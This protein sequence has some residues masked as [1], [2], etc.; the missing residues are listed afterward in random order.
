MTRKWI[1]LLICAFMVTGLS[2]CGGQ[3]EVKDSRSDM[4]TEKNEIDEKEEGEPVELVASWWGSQIR[5][6]RFISCFDLYTEQ[7][8]D[9]SIETQTSSFD[10]YFVTL[11]AAAAGGTLP[12][13]MMSQ[14]DYM[15][16]YVN[17]GQL[18]D[19]TPYIE[20][21]ALDVS[22]VS[23]AVLDTGRMGDGV[24]GITAGTAA[25][26]MV[27][28][29]TLLDDLGIEIKDFMTID[30]FTSICKEVFEKTGVKTF[31]GGP[32]D[33]MEMMLRSEGK[34]LFEDG[35]LGVDSWEELLPYWELLEQGNEE[36]WL[37]DY[38]V[39]IGR[40]ALEEDPLINFT[41]PETQ[42]WCA[43]YNSNQMAAL[44]AA[45][46]EAVKLGITTRPSDDANKS[47]YVRQSMC[48]TVSAA[49]QHVDETIAL[50]NW[51]LNNEEPNDIIK[52]E[53]GVPAS[54]VVAEHVAEG[55]DETSSMIFNYITN[56]V[57]PNSSPA[58]PVPPSGVSQIRDGLMEDI[59]EKVYYGEYTPEQAAKELY[60]Q[61][62]KILQE[63]KE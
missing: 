16:P 58:N 14:S 49:S 25:L 53:P 44:Q 26:S 46:P 22:N 42:S 47:N 20:S 56:V 29:K 2:A 9:V 21:G 63:A 36:G 30:D 8:K 45:A 37:L 34:V 48:W 39:R 38:S 7:N 27:Y 41:S 23:K 52:G 33:G 3:G 31:L 59:N 55:L 40:T 19:L 1:S 10:D 60:E 51:W 18:L 15:A 12:D 61:G 4:Q 35:R 62:N 11:S 43:T 57:A 28:N 32:C 54:T 6:E 50:L 17:A 13:L 5:N 24:Y